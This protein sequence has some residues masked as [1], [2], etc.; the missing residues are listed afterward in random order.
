MRFEQ[1]LSGNGFAN[2]K[3]IAKGWTSDVFVAE[4]GGGG[5]VA[6]KVLR[7]KSNRKGMVLREAENLKAANS[8]GVGPKLLAFDEIANVVAM[9]FI[10]GISFDKWLDSNPIKTVLLEFIDELYSQARSLD[11]IGLDHGQ[12][13]GRGRN[14][15]VRDNLPVII[16]FEKASMHRKCHN[17][18]VLESFLFK[19]RD[20][21][22]V[23]KIRRIL[24]G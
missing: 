13:A 2:P 12:L 5:R 16:D 8:V 10:D 1:F 3:K 19:S 18:A 20:S 15:L 21:G 17:V 22:V 24:G 9:E 11:E 14:I 23:K 4:S 7:A 6:L